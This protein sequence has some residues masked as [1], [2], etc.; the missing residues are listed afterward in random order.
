MPM[1]VVLSHNFVSPITD[2]LDST[3]LGPDEWNDSHATS[4]A[5]NK[6]LGR[7]TAGTGAIEELT[8]GTNLS[9]AGTTLNAGSTDTYR[10]ILTGDVTFYVGYLNGTIAGGSSYT[11]GLY[12]D[13][14]LT[15][16][17][18]T[19]ARANI[20]VAGNAVT[21]V[22]I[23]DLTSV[24]SGYVITDVLSATAAS[25][26]GT[27]S[28]FTYTVTSVGSDLTGDGTATTP[29]ATTQKAFDEIAVTYDFGGFD[30][31][32]QIYDT[33]Y[34]ASTVDM[35]GRGAM[36]SIG[37]WLG[38]GSLNFIGALND[39]SEGIGS[40][41]SVK[42]DASNN[43]DLNTSTAIQERV[44]ADI[45]SWDSI[46]FNA[47]AT[48]TFFAALAGK[49]T[50]NNLAFGPNAGDPAI[51][52]PRSPGFVNTPSFGKIWFLGTSPLT[53]VGG[54]WFTAA[55]ATTLEAGPGVTIECDFGAFFF[56]HG[57][58]QVIGVTYAGNWSAIKLSVDVT[59]GGVFHEIIL[60]GGGV[61]SGTLV[62]GLPAKVSA[63]GL[64]D[65]TDFSTTD[66]VEYGVT[67]HVDQRPGYY[68]PTTGAT[69]DILTGQLSN[70]IDPAG[71]IA[72][73]TVNMPADP[74]GSSGKQDGTLVN[75]FFSQNV[76]AITFAGSS[77]D[78]VV[79]APTAVVAGQGVHA[80]F[81]QS[82]TTWYFGV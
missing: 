65:Y 42:I 53:V 48:R 3:L 6:L 39:T 61:G 51:G 5:T 37:P 46:Q 25:I 17:S 23:Y 49:H 10:T 70:I 56:R 82:N 72:T 59:E 11:D 30:V 19:G 55:F 14:V 74:A 28:G 58:G 68:V 52:A 64:Y 38:G 26:G 34:A 29:W 60:S 67:G 36:L 79:A 62:P 40:L 18:G 22:Q 4:M 24:P 33:H 69:V 47:V 32:V 54:G 27:G 44:A 43:V 45:M 13:V 81:K 77:G 71:T 57:E 78:T 9:F 2:Q 16:G 80:I 7:A 75:L 8:L 73:L 35:E 20:L 66:F 12:P 21:M 50:V 41:P 76:T 31:T 15:G 63:G 1:A